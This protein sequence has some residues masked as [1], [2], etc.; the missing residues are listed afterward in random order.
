M[1]HILIVL[2]FIA[3]IGGLVF[4]DQV[5]AV[6]S[7]MTPLEILKVIWSFILHAAMTTVIGYGV[8]LGYREIVLP[9]LRVF[10]LSS[11][12]ALRWKRK[13]VRRGRIQPKPS[14]PRAPRMNKD[15]VLYWLANQ[16]QR[17]EK[18]ARA[19]Q[20]GAGNEPPEIRLG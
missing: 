6:F 5:A 18:P 9:G 1:K 14:T 12:Q 11:T 16:L 20:A 19:N 17:K 3:A 2:A 15:A 4:Y 8:M 10:R 13:A 7:G